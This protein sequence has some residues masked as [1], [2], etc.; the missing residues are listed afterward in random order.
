MTSAHELRIGTLGAA[1]VHIVKQQTPSPILY[2]TVCGRSVTYTSSGRFAQVTCKQCRRHVITRPH[3][4]TDLT[5]NRKL[6]T[7][8]TYSTYHGQCLPNH[9]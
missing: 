8:P 6:P 3:R 5:A 9:S 7:S 1:H 4:T 2:R